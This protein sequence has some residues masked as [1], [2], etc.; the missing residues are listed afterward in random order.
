MAAISATTLA[1]DFITPMLEVMR[2]ARSM[3]LISCLPPT[4]VRSQKYYPL[5]VFFTMRAFIT[6]PTELLI[7]TSFLSFAMICAQQ[8]KN[9]VGLL[10]KRLKI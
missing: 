7:I 9:W 2:L 8:R 1:V 5:S 4:I 10:L 6:A 3:S